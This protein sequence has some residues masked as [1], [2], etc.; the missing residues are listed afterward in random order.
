MTVVRAAAILGARRAADLFGAKHASALVDLLALLGTAGGTSVARGALGA[1]T[2]NLL[3]KLEGLGAAMVPKF[4]RK[5]PAA[6]ATIAPQLSS[7]I[8]TAPTMLR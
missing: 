2:P 4:L 6:A 8:P 7:R 3:P 1:A 5:A